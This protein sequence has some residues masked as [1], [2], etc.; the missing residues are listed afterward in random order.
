MT[1]TNTAGTS[2]SSAVSNA[3]IPNAANITK[4]ISTVNNSSSTPPPFCTFA[5][6][7]TYGSYSFTVYRGTTSPPTTTATGSSDVSSITTNSG[8]L[9][10]YYQLSITPYSGPLVGGAVS[11][12][13]GTTRTTTIIRNTT[14][15]SAITDNY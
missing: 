9:N 8:G 7:G 3:V 6:T 1:T 10:Y 5:L 15:Q 11:G 13:A 12:T 14:S 2:P 4:I